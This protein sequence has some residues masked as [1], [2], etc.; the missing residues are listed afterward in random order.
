MCPKYCNEVNLCHFHVG[1]DLAF[2]GRTEQRN[3]IEMGLSTPGGVLSIT[4][5]V[6]LMAKYHISVSS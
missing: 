1:L 4:S 5:A 3:Y 2:S 6:N